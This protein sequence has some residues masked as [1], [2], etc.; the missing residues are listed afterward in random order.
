MSGIFEIVPAELGK[1]FGMNFV[2]GVQIRVSFLAAILISGAVPVAQAELLP[3][4]IP[5]ALEA[6][7]AVGL[8]ASAASPQDS[9]AGT[10]SAPGT[11]ALPGVVDS[12]HSGSAPMVAYAHGQLTINAENV[13][14]SDILS[15][16]HNIMG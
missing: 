10:R 4:I 9:Q 7:Q 12:G 6:F 13:P 5:N 2:L 8:H 15:A 11:H 3:K 16:L 1:A 14:L